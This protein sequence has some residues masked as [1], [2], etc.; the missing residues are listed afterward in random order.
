MCLYVAVVAVVF[1]VFFSIADKTKIAN[2]KGEL[3][4]RLIRHDFKYF[5]LI[6]LKNYKEVK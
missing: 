1:V 4:F 6:E 2:K 5:K 3:Q